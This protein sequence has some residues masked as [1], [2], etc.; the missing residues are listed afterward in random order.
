MKRIFKRKESSEQGQILVIVGV[1]MLVM[2]AMVGLVID[3]GNAWGQQRQTQ[4]GADA[5]ANAGATVI[6]QSLK[7]ATKTDGDVGCAVEQAASL[8]G[9]GNPKA[10]YTDV[11]GSVLGVDVGPCVAGGGATIPSTAQGVKAS[12]DKVFDTYLARVVGVD[13]M[14]A[15]AQATAVAGL[16]TAPCPAS[17][18]NLLPVTFP[19][20]ISACNGTNQQ[21]QI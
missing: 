3:G 18:C 5:M 9:V 17:D 19:L 1:G 15:S 8:N 11:N 6:A 20:T 7:G 2:I 10:T 4:N 12:G 14:T 13:K 16:M 21:I